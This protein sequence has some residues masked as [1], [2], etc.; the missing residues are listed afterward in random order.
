MSASAP[1]AFPTPLPGPEEMALLKGVAI[2]EIDTAVIITDA[3]GRFLYLNPRFSELTGYLPEEVT[4]RAIRD[5]C[6]RHAASCGHIDDIL[7]R[8]RLKRQYSGEVLIHNKDGHPMWVE[9]NATAVRDERKRQR[10]IATV[11]DIT[12]AKLHDTLQRKVLE[13]L[14]EDRPLVDTLNLICHEVETLLH[15][16]TMSVLRI[17]D[18]HL[19]PLAGPNLPDWYNNAINGVPVGPNQGSCGTAAFRGEPVL[20]NDIAT[21]PLWA[22]YRKAVAPL[23]FRACWSTPIKDKTGKVVGTFAFYAPKPLVLNT[24]TQSM[25]D[26]CSRLCSLAFEKCAFQDRI[27]FLAHHDALTGLPNR[28]FFQ[29][30]LAEEAA[31]ATRQKTQLALHIIDLDRFKEVNDTLGHPVGDEV[32][33]TVARTLQTHAAPG[34]VTARLGGDEF[35]FLQV[36]VTDRTQAELRATQLVDGIREALAAQF[37]HHGP[38]TSA[39]AGFALFPDE[40]PSFDHLIRHADM[41]LYRAKTEGRNRW[42][43][44]DATMAQALLYRRRLES[45]LRDALAADGEGLSLVYQPQFCLNDSRIIGYEVLARWKHPSFGAIPPSEFIPIAEEAGM[46]AELGAWILNHAC[47]AASTWA[48]DLTIA[49][50]LSPAQIFEGDLTA[51]VKATLARTGLDPARLEL[52]VTEGVLIDN[53]ER[54]LHVLH[55]LKDL[56]VRISMDDFGTGYSSLSYLQTFPFDAI[57]IDRSFTQGLDGTHSKHGLHADAIVRAVIG[58]GHAIGIPVIAEGVESQPQFDRLKALKC[59]AV[60]GYLIG[61]PLPHLIDPLPEFDAKI[62][63]IA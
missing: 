49:V 56:G 5:L 21:D 3:S 15:G 43:A 9:L 2:E 40:A 30:R 11:T 54:A 27:Q 16:V 14:L 6:S 23:G 44:F 42:R 13:A 18:D 29:A 48:D 8:V 25:V 17:V 47:D 10:L 7:S 26:I 31:R 32:L 39:S 22:E 20:V 33:K 34:D 50:N 52:E 1:I 35:V 24:F 51:F 12:Y 55:G 60:Q 19:V 28:A 41:A 4:G 46:I 58:L 62:V 61:K 37:D 59:D 53:T 45:D 57:K 63:R 38:Q 36:G